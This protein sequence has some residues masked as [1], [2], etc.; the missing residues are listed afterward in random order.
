MKRQTYLLSQYLKE[1]GIRMWIT[2][3]AYFINGNSPVE[4]ESIINDIS[5]LDEIIHQPQGKIY[6]DK[7]ISK[8][9]YILSN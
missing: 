4:D 8:A 5:E 6:D 7:V 3:F 2:P 9:V 1:N